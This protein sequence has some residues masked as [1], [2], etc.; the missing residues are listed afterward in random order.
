MRKV[1]M[2]LLVRITRLLGIALVAWLGSGL[3]SAAQAKPVAWPGRPFAATSVWNRPLAA[4]APMSSR[5]RSYVREVVRQVDDYGPWLNTYSYSVPVY[6]VG[7][8]QPT[9]HVTLDT[10]G[11]DLQ[12]AFSAVPLP[13]HAKPA[14]GNDEQLTVWQPSTNTMWEFWHLHRVRGKWHARWGGKMTNVSHNPGYF[15]HDATTDDWGATATGLPLLGGLITFADLE[16][17]YINHALAI[18]L[19]ETEPRYWVWP[20]QR[21]DGDVFTAGVPGIPEGTRFRLD[22]HLNIASLHLSPLVRMIARAAQRYGIIVRDKSGAVSFYG[23]DPTQGD[24]NL[25]TPALEGQYPNNLLRT[26]PWSRLQ[27]LR[28]TTSCCW[29][30][31]S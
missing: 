19:V 16:R 1:T 4:H 13:A 15:T 27:A 2:T 10:W 28:S 17:G 6:V 14:A 5:S 20:A 30:P 11:P 31:S 12:D 26:F 3:L 25:W 29:G 18:S 21:T 8:G 24:E 23:Q 22:P 7:A 9:R